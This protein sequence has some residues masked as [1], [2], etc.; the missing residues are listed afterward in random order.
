MS[1]QKVVVDREEYQWVPGGSLTVQGWKAVE[2]EKAEIEVLDDKGE[3]VKTEVTFF[4]RPDVVK[5]Y[6]AY[7]VQADELGFRV[8]LDDLE[9]FIKAGKG[10]KILLKAGNEEKTL[11]ERDAA[12]LEKGWKAAS[13]QYYVDFCGLEDRRITIRGWML[14]LT[15]ENDLSVTDENGNEVPG[16]LNRSLRPDV[17]EN[18]GL[19]GRVPENTESG[20]VF[21]CPRSEFQGKKLVFHMKNTLVEKCYEISMKK[22]DFQYS[23]AGRLKKAIG[24]GKLAENK[25][26][27]K[28]RG[29]TGLLDHVKDN[30]FTDEEQ[31]QRWLKKKRPSAWELHRQS[32]RTFDYEPLISIVIPLYNTPQEYLRK[33]LQS[34]TAQSYGKFELCLADG[35]TKK[36]P[37]A[38]VK[39]FYGNDPRIRLKHL[40]LNAGISENTN[41]AIRMATG[42][43]LMFADHDDF[44]EPDA[45]YEMVRALNEN[46]E[47]DLIY[48]DE[49]LCD[50][51]GE[52]FF[53]PRMKPDFNPDFLRSINYICHLV[54][55]RKSL[56][57]EVGLL[58]KQ[59]DG[60]QDY[61][62]LLRCIE[63]TDR[64]YHIPKVLYH[65]RVSETSTAGNQDSK[66]YAIDA[67]KLALTEHYAR[68]GYEAEVEYTGIFI[69][70]RMR[71]KLKSQPLVTI[72]IPNK[73]QVETL[74]NCLSSIYE[75]TDYPYFEILVVENN[76]EKEETF[77]YYEKMK[78]EHE[79]FHVVTYQGGFNYSAINNFGVRHAKGEYLLFLN[80]DTEVISPFWIR[81]M[82]GFCQ[83]EDTAA[84][85]AKLFY[86]DGLVQHCGVV[87]GIANYAG[88]VQNFK[89]RRDNGYFG[90]LRAVQD[91]SAVTAACMLVKRSVF[92]EI[93]GFDESFEVA[94]N[95]VDLCLRIR[96]TGK[97]IVQDPNVE[98]Y[99]YESKSRGYENTPEKL[100]RFKGEVIRF[101]KRWKAFLEKGDP[102]YSP[103]L[104]LMNGECTLRKEHEIPEEWEKLFPD[105]EEV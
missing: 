90:R 91:I 69:M 20:F 13:I 26:I 86:P 43:F 40:K 37:A 104:T 56:A 42:E 21:S 101:R 96:E 70:Y 67:G 84:V 35:S 99:H 92:E 8:K 83:R 4:L 62:F 12:E 59:C 1:I 65:W 6:P 44:L 28:K 45:L 75:K 31:Y 30:Y 53:A 71:L 79:N 29:I 73:D 46:R 82:L 25:E 88:H 105:G 81:E 24:R 63:K 98:L 102:Y 38:F 17:A 61:D 80:N 51:K 54:L 87:V 77:A 85:G 78:Q 60:A 36:G 32:K 27:L 7:A 14:D 47:L 41:E 19:E 18:L 50:E 10:I 103:N 58:R 23:K 57:E 100:A 89:T 2:G 15:G 68:L 72:L 9:N 52:C 3:P 94:F 97:L 74:A 11:L 33:L 95:D 64:V 39:K 22:I 76:S 34:I 5:R 49:D 66:T 93:G 16:V 55:V 48:T